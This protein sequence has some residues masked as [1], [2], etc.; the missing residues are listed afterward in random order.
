MIA[1]LTI[2]VDTRQP[3]AGDAV[4]TAIGISIKE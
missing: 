2:V 3:N 1:T 4:R